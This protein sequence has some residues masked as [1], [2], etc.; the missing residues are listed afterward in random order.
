MTATVTLRYQRVHKT[1]GGEFPYVGTIEF[2]Q[3]KEE[4]QELPFRKV[5][6]RLHTI[7]A[8]HAA[9]DRVIFQRV[10]RDGIMPFELGPK[11]VELLRTNPVEA[12]RSMN[13]NSDPSVQATGQG[14]T[15]EFGRYLYI[16]IETGKA[17][18]PLDGDWKTLAFGHQSG[19][20]IRGKNN[21]SSSWLSL[22]AL[23]DD[24]PEGVSNIER[25]VFTR[26][27]LV[28][29]EELLKTD[30]NNFYFPLPWNINGPWVSREELMHL[31]AKTKENRS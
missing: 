20:K 6:S 10:D 30:K 23:I 27:A 24:A 16:R 26:W 7:L 4:F 22:H 15:A 12:Y 3:A 11:T 1:V 18:C 14:L 8:D 5:I 2:G 31:Y 21:N 28:D 25:I 29:I 13:F 19:W 17:Q 9:L